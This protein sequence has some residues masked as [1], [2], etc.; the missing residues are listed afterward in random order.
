MGAQNTTILIGLG[1]YALLMVVIGLWSARKETADGFVIGSR[2]VGLIP[3]MSSL[4]TGFRDGSGLVFWVGA[5]A[6]FI[7]G[8][9]ISLLGGVLLGLL[10]FSFVGPRVRRM[11]KER[12]YIT[13]GQIIRDELGSRSEK[14]SS[15]IVAVFSVILI[16]VQLFVSGNLISAISPLSS[17]LS[18]ALVAAVVAL[19]MF[20]GGYGNVIKTD[21]IQFLLV[22]S[23]I[24]LPFFI[25]IDL[26][27]FFD[28]ENYKGYGTSMD[29]AF[30]LMGMFYIV[31]SSD[32]WQRLFS[33]RNKKVVRYGFPSAVIPLVIM[34][35]SLFFLGV[36]AREYLPAD[37]EWG[38]AFFQLYEFNA[39]PPYILAY[40]AV[41]CVAITMSTLDTLC[42]LSASTFLKNIMSESYTEKRGGYVRLTRVAIIVVLTLSAIL[43]TTIGDVIKY[44][45]DA[46]SLLFVLAPLYV[47][48][49]L[50]Y[51]KKS[52]R[53]DSMIAISLIVSAAIYIYMF[54]NNHF[55]D[56][57]MI[58]VPTLICSVLTIG[59]VIS[60]EIAKKSGQK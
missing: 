26:S 11:A 8:G 47:L 22:V 45:F 21:V 43:A 17:E 28:A 56:L 9:L 6:T 16:S 50:G 44:I 60:E 33:A 34:T 1:L 18:I 29:I 4:A 46:V 24:F 48:A 5:G 2:N 53:L 49:G 23:L 58:Y 20:F 31:V 37:T 32:A 54:T 38:K 25:D 3:T 7:F 41:V 36:A 52:A 15:L 30:F 42:Y 13:I 55:Q 57:I 12:G 35:L 10:F 39:L 51:L 19:Y 14:V 40:V 59:A 27:V